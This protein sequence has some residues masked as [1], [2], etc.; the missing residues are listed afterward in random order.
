MIK[1]EEKEATCSSWVK[2]EIT[3][4]N[5]K[6]YENAILANARSGGGCG[7]DWSVGCKIY[8]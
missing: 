8:F 3:I 6:E 7:C 5:L 2:P 1:M 4:I